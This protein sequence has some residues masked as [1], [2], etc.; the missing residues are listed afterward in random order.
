MNI[1]FANRTVSVK[2]PNGSGT[3]TVIKGEAWNA[4]HPFVKARSDLFDKQ[5]DPEFVRGGEIER[6]T[7]APGEKRNRR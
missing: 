7:A 1:V 6:A 5:P 4:N 3:V 2:D